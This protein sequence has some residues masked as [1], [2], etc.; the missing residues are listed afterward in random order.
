MLSLHDVVKSHGRTRR[1]RYWPD[2]CVDKS[3]PQ[4][5]MMVEAAQVAY[6]AIVLVPTIVQGLA[7]SRERQ[8]RHK[9]H[10]VT[11]FGQA[12]CNGP[13]IVTRCFEAASHGSAIRPQ[14]LP[15]DHDC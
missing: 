9:P 10:L 2:C 1:P 6:L 15:A 11:R 5:E 13:V 14:D 12:P 4:L 7:G 8:R 3:R